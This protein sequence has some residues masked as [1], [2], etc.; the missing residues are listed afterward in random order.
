MGNSIRSTMYINTKTRYKRYN[1]SLKKMIHYKF[2]QYNT[3][4]PKTFKPN[5]LDEQK[6]VSSPEF[7]FSFA[8]FNRNYL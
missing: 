8:F 3:V 2:I 7:F 6:D 5:L 4:K 1:H